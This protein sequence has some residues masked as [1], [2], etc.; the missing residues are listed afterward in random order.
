M[1]ERDIPL[2]ESGYPLCPLCRDEGKGERQAFDPYL[3]TSKEGQRKVVTLCFTHADN[4]ERGTF[5]YQW[6]LLLRGY[7]VAKLDKRLKELGIT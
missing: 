2:S 3:L 7:E 1:I 5:P 4:L 6:T